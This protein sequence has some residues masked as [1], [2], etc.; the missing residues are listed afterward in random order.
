M[1]SP[2][3]EESPEPEEELQDED[4]NGSEGGYLFT[5]FLLGLL[6]PE[7][8]LERSDSFF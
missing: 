3:P 2:S 6:R 1:S 8:V 5:P 7:P 4:D